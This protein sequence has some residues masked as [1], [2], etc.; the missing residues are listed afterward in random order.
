MKDGM[1]GDR[2]SSVVQRLVPLADTWV[3]PGVKWWMPPQTLSGQAWHGFSRLLACHEAW[4]APPQ[5]VR[6]LLDCEKHIPSDWWLA[7]TEHIA[8]SISS[9][10][11]P[12]APEVLTHC[13]SWLSDISTQVVGVCLR[14]QPGSR[15]E[16]SGL[17]PGVIW[18][19]LFSAVGER[20]VWDVGSCSLA[21]QGNG[22]WLGDWPCKT[23][24]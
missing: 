15:W 17:L 22:V 21:P 3:Q 11:F 9:V 4:K 23:L 2:V 8:V 14:P 12:T 10:L 16:P 5:G 20:K 6:A 7:A 13:S 24:S 1:G 19:L 18:S